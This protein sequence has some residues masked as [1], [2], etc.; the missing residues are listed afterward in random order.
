VK[1]RL[2]QKH[3]LSRSRKQFNHWMTFGYQIS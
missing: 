3:I 1:D 2:L